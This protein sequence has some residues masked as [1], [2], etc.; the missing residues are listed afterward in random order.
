MCDLD[1]SAGWPQL[2]VI[3][4]NECWLRN[5]LIRRWARTRVLSDQHFWFE[6]WQNLDNCIGKSG[7]TKHLT[8]ALFWV[9]IFERV[10]GTRAMKI[11]LSESRDSWAFFDLCRANQ[12]LIVFLITVKAE[13]WKY[14]NLFST[15]VSV[16]ED[17][18]VK[19]QRA[20]GGYLG[21]QR[22][23]RTWLPA[24]SL[25]ELEARIDPGISEWGN[26]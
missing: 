17:K 2:P 11:L 22:R 19:L 12:S 6:V 4:K 7:K 15:T 25:G 5:W 24:I 20:H 9:W 8:D 18:L 13:R 16:Q 21:T 3:P 26:P 1:V 14:E 23:W 10:F